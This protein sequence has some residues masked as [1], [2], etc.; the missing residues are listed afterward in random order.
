VDIALQRDFVASILSPNNRLFVL[1]RQGNRRPSALV[2]IAV[3]PVMLALMIVSQVIARAL[4]RP[5]FPNGVRS[6]ANPI[7]EIIGFLSIYLGLWVWLRSWSKRPFRTLGFE[8]QRVLQR[9]LRGALVAV[10]MVLAMAGLTMI[11]GAS[12]LPGE[13]RTR[14]LAAVGPG[15]LILLATTVQSSA[16]EALFRGWLLSAIGSRYRPWIAVL[17][18]SL[19]FAT[20]H[21]LNGPT[22]LAWVNLFFFGTFAAIWAPAEGGLW[23]AS[24]WH[25]VWNWVEGGCLGMVVDR[26]PGSGLFVSI[27]TKG[28]DLI[29]GGAFGPEG[30]LAVTAVLLIG[31]SMLLLRTR[32][33]GE[34]SPAPQVVVPL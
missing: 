31:I 11:A 25:T 16:E 4:V 1:A 2:A 29:T 12:L 26:S 34:P 3:V 17:I 10:L 7:A 18:S 24:A 21:L 30:G 33:F 5:I 28:P 27:Q 6:V 8:H 15:L 22:P 9:A 32:A 13:L 20:A 23:G 14:G 19:L